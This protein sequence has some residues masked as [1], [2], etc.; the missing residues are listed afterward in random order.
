[1]KPDKTYQGRSTIR[2]YN[3]DCMEL[4]DIDRE[5]DLA[6]VDP[7]YGIGQFWNKQKHTYHYGGKDWNSEPPSPEYFQQLREVSASQIIFGGN[8]Y[9]KHL[10]AT[11]SWIYWRKGNDVEKMNTSEGELAWTSFNIPMR[12]VYVQWSGGRKGR[13]TGIEC[14]HPCQRP[15]DLHRWLLNNY[16]SEGDT[17]LDTHGG[18]MSLAIACWEEGFDL[19]ICELD[20]DYF[21]AAVKRFENHIAQKTLF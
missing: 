18:S 12:D 9:A 4:M 1:M 6:I 2:M 13:E 10:P 5:W 17:I 16:A 20:P 15:I 3:C 21:K 14:I 11:N 7:P 19:D 8:Y